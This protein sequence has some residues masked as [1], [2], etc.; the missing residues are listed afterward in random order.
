MINRKMIMEVMFN[1]FLFFLLEVL[2]VLLGLFGLFSRFDGGQ[3]LYAGIEY[4]LL[5]QLLLVILFACYI[6]HKLLKKNI[7]D[8]IIYLYCSYIFVIV[9]CFL[10]FWDTQNYSYWFIPLLFPLINYLLVVI[11]K[12]LFAKK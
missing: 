11:Y 1:N 5:I 9:F 6:S 7:S 12:V 10:L 4:L 3:G 2:F 8:K